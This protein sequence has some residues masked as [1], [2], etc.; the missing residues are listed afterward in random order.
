MKTAAARCAGN[1]LDSGPSR[2]TTIML[3]ITLMFTI[4]ITI[5]ITIIITSYY[6]YHY[7]YYDY[8]Y[9]YATLL[10]FYYYHVYYYYGQ[11]SK[12]HV[13]FC[14]LDSGNLKFEKVRTNKQH[15]FFPDLRRSIWNF[16]I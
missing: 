1:R 8:A 10:L 4:T 16:A 12:L 5:T 13:W 11:F 7:N 3:T 9:Y 15:L 2:A 6:Y 14:G